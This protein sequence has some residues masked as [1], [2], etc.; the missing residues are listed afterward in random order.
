[1]TLNVLGRTILDN[2]PVIRVT[3]QRAEQFRYCIRETEQRAEQ[4][5]TP[6]AS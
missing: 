6:L 2:K 1:M 3:E 4:L 5:T